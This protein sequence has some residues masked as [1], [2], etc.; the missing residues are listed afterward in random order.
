[1][2]Y[3]DVYFD[4]PD[5]EFRRFERELRVRHVND[6]ERGNGKAFVTYKESPF[7]LETKSKEEL[8]VE[9]ENAS[10]FIE[11]FEKLGFVQVIAFEK[12]CVTYKVVFGEMTI[13]VT[14]VRIPELGPPFLECEI[15][16]REP[17]ETPRA[18]ETLRRFASV[19]GFSSADETSD[20]YTDLVRGSR[21]A[22]HRDET[23][24]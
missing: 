24:Q 5:G 13:D 17:T 4:H 11:I 15:Q 1:M 16:V 19:L 7:D 6:C 23:R 18:L 2:K 20:Y 10:R 9:V 22:A 21:E 8:E 12:D 3:R 14:M